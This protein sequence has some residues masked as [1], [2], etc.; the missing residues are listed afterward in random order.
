MKMSIQ[1]TKMDVARVA[2]MTIVVTK[3]RWRTHQT[4]DGRHSGGGGG[5]GSQLIIYP[6]DDTRQTRADVSVGLVAGNRE[7]N[8]HSLAIAASG[9]DASCFWPEFTNEN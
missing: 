1:W 6:A 5:R 8:C 7:P 2:A 9:G 4:S 3:S